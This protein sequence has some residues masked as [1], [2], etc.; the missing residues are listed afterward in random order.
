[1]LKPGTR[2]PE[3]LL[4]DDEGDD[5]GLSA[6]LQNGPLIL[7]FYP[8]DFTPGCTKE[9]CAFRDRMADYGEAG[10]RV[11][12]VSLDS[13]ES[14]RLFREKYGLN[15]P[16]LS[17]ESHE[18]LEGYGVWKPHPVYGMTIERSTFLIDGDGRIERAWRRV[19]P[20]GHAD[21]VVGAL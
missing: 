17:D 5:V 4:P 20:L 12:G 15:F 1:M 2:A 9:A 8:A 10:I 14:H 3:F 13:P 18:M 16:L 11:Y 6:L 7:Y 21:E 19:S